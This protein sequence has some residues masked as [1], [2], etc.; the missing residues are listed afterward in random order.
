MA[1]PGRA[2]RNAGRRPAAR[3]QVLVVDLVDAE[4]ALLHHPGVGV[5]FPRAVGAGPGAELAADAGVGVDQHDAVLRPLVGGAGRADGDAG[6]VLAVQAGLGE[7]HRAAVALVAHH[8]EGVDAVEPHAAGIGAVRV[9]VGQRRR[10][11]G[12]VPL[13]AVHRAGMAADADVQVDDQAQLHRAGI[14][15]QAGHA[16]CP[17]PGPGFL[18]L[19][20]P[21]ATPGTLTET[22]WRLPIHSWKGTPWPSRAGCRLFRSAP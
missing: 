9:A 22:S 11:A 2:G 8:L 15:R 20:L 17:P 16:P 12:G 10:M 14:A 1:R 3:V 13:L 21:S 5:V 7:V 18:R 6:R 19:P 4:R